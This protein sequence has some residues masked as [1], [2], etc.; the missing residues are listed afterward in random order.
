MLRKFAH[1]DQFEQ[2]DVFVIVVTLAL[3]KHLRRPR[4]WELV[5]IE[6]LVGPEKL[7]H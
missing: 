1:V 4:E 2:S 3:P 7:F 6:Y 5:W